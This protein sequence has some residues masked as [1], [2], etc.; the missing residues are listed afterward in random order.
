[1]SG[2]CASA[3]GVYNL[4]LVP[5]GHVRFPRQILPEPRTMSHAVK[6]ETSKFEDGV[7]GIAL[8]GVLSDVLAAMFYVVLFLAADCIPI[9][10]L[11][12]FRYSG[13]VLRLIRARSLY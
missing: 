13:S 5:K 3:A 4:F 1:M 6:H 11:L 12:F 10:A 8:L 9:L 2:H 7:L